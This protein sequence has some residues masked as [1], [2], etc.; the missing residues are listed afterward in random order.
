MNTPTVHSEPTGV[1]LHAPAVNGAPVQRRVFSAPELAFI[2]GVPAAWG[3]LL[4]FHPIGG[5]S[6]Y[7]NI[8]G[9][10]TAWITVHLGMG[11]FV[12]LFA[13]VVYLLLRDVESTAAAVSRIGLGVFA[14][15][16]AAWELVLGVGTG[17]LTDETNALPEAQQAVGADLVESYGENG[18]IVILSVVGSL[19]L[20]VGMIGAV[21][22]LRG[23]YRLGPVPLVLMLLSL[24]LIAIHEPPF[25][26][27]GLAL[28]IVAALLY[29]RQRSSAPARNTPPLDELVPGPPA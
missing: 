21:V 9:N 1:P 25:G 15:L 4:L 26:P 27:V 20:A 18:V 13:G 11:I 17:I 19:G 23:A 12:P 29:V 2:V 3:I 14:V 22:A 5:D 28:F 6:F 16:Y 24:P 8:D 10:V 7:E